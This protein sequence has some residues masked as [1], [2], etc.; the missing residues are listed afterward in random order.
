MK[1]KKEKK[2]Q[3]I[4]ER[5]IPTPSPKACSQIDKALLACFPYCINYMGV[6]RNLQSYQEIKIFSSSSLV[7]KFPASLL[8]TQPLK[9]ESHNAPRREHYVGGGGGGVG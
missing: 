1:E 6:N 3:T 2:L 5:F 4:Q 7:P 9:P 8:R